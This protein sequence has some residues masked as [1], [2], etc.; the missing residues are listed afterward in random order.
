M[1]LKGTIV[2]L[3]IMTHS[4]PQKAVWVQ[5]LQHDLLVQENGAKPVHFECIK[6]SYDTFILCVS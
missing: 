4:K 1:R 6:K 5:L 2:Y 3:K